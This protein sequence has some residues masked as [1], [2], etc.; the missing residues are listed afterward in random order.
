HAAAAP[1]PAGQK[2]AAPAPVAAGQKHTAPAPVAAPAPAGPKHA[3]PAPVAG[4]PG[5]GH[6]YLVRPGD[7]LSGIATAQRVP[8]GWQSI[9]EA[10][11]G[12]LHSA[13]LIRPGQQLNLG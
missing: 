10:N 2:H 6:T 4:T 12:G 3:T 9:Y 11:R 8:G 5:A 1:A 13:N 7:T